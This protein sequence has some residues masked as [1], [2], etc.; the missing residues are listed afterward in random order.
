MIRHSAY[1]SVSGYRDIEMT[2][3][4][5]DYD[6]W[7]RLY[8]AGIRGYVLTEPLYC[9]YDGRSAAKRRTFKRRIN[10]AK[11]RWAGYKMLSIPVPLRIYAVKPVLIGLIPQRLY[12][13]IR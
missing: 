8:A 2:R 5:E 6:L 13:L 7:F 11:V 3:G 4:V 1:E 12:K 10:E 9:M